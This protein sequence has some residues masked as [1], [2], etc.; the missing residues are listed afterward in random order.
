VSQEQIIP[1]CY[2]VTPDSVAEKLALREQNLKFINY[3]PV[4]DQWM[5]QDKEDVTIDAFFT[6]AK[7]ELKRRGNSAEFMK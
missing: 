7:C 1:V 3:C 2:A 4:C 6:C 5:E